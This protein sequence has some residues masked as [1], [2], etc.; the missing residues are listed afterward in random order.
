MQFSQKKQEKYIR[1]MAYTKFL[2]GKPV[3]GITFVSLLS[4]GAFSTSVVNNDFA[5]CKNLVPTVECMLLFSC[6]IIQIFLCQPQLLYKLPQTV[7]FS[8]VIFMIYP[9][10][11]YLFHAVLVT[12]RC[13][14]TFLKICNV[15]FF[16]L[17]MTYDA[18]SSSSRE[19]LRVSEED[20]RRMALTYYSCTC[21]Q[22]PGQ[23]LH[24]RGL[25]EGPC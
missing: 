9:K 16:C 20:K 23:W 1:E 2:R 13:Y 12:L 17:S 24:E 8:A 10:K 5:Y 19:E 7:R 6:K 22:Q 4:L 21:L 18:L 14:E 25:L 11:R 15:F 3:S